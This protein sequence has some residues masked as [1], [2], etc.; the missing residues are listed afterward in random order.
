MSEHQPPEPPNPE[1][2]VKTYG[3]DDPDR[4][5][6]IEAARAAA[7]AE[8]KSNREKLERYVSYGLNEEDAQA[9]IEHEDMLKERRDAAEAGETERRIHP[10]I[11]VR[12]LVDYTEGHDIGDWI[13]ASQDLEDIHADIRNIL[14][15]SLHAHWTGQPAEEW[16]IHDQDGFGQITLSEYE[17]LDV[18][19]ALGK[20]I[21][22]HGLAFSAW[23]EIND[24]R[25]VY[26]LA[27]F[28]EAYMGDFG[29]REEYAEHIVD[30]MNGDEELAKLSEWTRG[31]VRFDFEYMIHEMETS[32]DFRFADHPGGVWVFNGRV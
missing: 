23:A 14:S 9:L 28:S 6:E 30:E 20:G 3:T 26:T 12:S 24:E 17:S 13:D 15:R 19:C 2:G 10:R 25:D 4:Q 7:S 18:V 11:Y 8:R 22:E 1:Q 16:A 27:R 32:G 31:I 5:A 21:A 29:S